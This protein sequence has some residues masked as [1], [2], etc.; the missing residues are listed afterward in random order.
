ML[1]IDIKDKETNSGYNIT[2]RSQKWSGRTISYYV[3]RFKL[4]V[5]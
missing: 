3:N 5:Y 1:M 2:A 4:L